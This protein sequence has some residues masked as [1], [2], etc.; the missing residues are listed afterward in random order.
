[1]TAIILVVVAIGVGVA[2]RQYATRPVP[3]VAPEDVS[4]LTAAARRDL[5]GDA[6]NE[7]LLMRPGQRVTAGLVAVETDGV[8]GLTSGIGEAVTRTSRRI[9]GWQNG[10]VRSYALSIFAGTTVIV[11]LVMAVNAL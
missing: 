7:E 5:Y 8:D 6:V 1:M 4:V 9:R 2:Y 11:A 3:V 10:Y